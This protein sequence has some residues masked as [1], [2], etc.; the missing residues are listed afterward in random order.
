MNYQIILDR[1]EVILSPMKGYVHYFLADF[2][3]FIIT[4]RQIRTSKRFGHM[5][6]ELNSYLF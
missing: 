2:E 6:C 4:N 1:P 3:S 5:K